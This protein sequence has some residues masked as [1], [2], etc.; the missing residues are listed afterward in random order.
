MGFDW[1]VLFF[2]VGWACVEW[3]LALWC[4]T[5]WPCSLHCQLILRRDHLFTCRISWRH[6]PIRSFSRGG[7]RDGYDL[8]TRACVTAHIAKTFFCRFVARTQVAAPVRV[9]LIGR[10]YGWIIADLCFSPCPVFFISCTMPIG[11]SSRHGDGGFPTPQAS[12]QRRYDR[13]RRP[14]KNLADCCNHQGLVLAVYLD[15]RVY[16][17]SYVVVV[18]FILQFWLIR[19][20][21]VSSLMR[22]STRLQKV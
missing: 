19:D 1:C 20:R 4:V 18:A 9:T 8:G 5:C 15:F 12:L 3:R 17:N 7:S 6:A 2:F 10:V 21:L 11:D 13:S 16:R 22:T 14:R